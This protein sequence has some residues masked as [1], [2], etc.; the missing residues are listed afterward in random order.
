MGCV[1]PQS[2]SGP[3]N[4][5]VEN[6]IPTQDTLLKDINKSQRKIFEK[7]V[8]YF[9]K[10]N[11]EHDLPNEKLDENKFN[12]SIFDKGDNWEFRIYELPP[13]G[14]IWPGGSTV[15]LIRKK[16]LEILKVVPGR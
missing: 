12:F 11:K 8:K 7:I 14:V 16:D 13:A 2:D 10:F 15:V 3:A 5:I 6:S 1:R 9:D 4:Q